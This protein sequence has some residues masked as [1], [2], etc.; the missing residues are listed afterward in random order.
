MD[1]DRSLSPPASKRLRVSDARNDSRPP[2]SSAS[3]SSSDR[4]SL[5]PHSSSCPV[6]SSASSSSSPTFDTSSSTQPPPP[7]PLSGPPPPTS[8]GPKALIPKKRLAGVIQ[9]SDGSI[10]YSGARYVL[11]EPCAAPELPP[12]PLA[13]LLAVRTAFLPYLSDADAGS[14]LRAVGST[15]TASAL[16]S[17]FTFRRHVFQADTPAQLRRMWQ[18]YE[19]YGLRASHMCLHQTPTVG[20]R[21]FG[22]WTDRS[23][24]PPSLTALLLTSSTL[25]ERVAKGRLD[26]Q[27]VFSSEVAQVI[28]CPWTRLS[29]QGAPQ[30]LQRMLSAGE[31]REYSLTLT[32]PF[33]PVK[34]LPEYAD[35][36]GADQFID[37]LPL[38][39]LPAHILRLHITVPF[40]D[41][42]SLGAGVLPAQLQVLQI[43][44]C[45]PAAHPPLPVAALPLNLTHLVLLQY[46]APLLPGVLPN[47]LVQLYLRRWN[48]QL[49]P[50]VLPASL[51]ALQLGHFDQPL[52]AGALPIGLT[53]LTLVRFKQVIGEGV[54]PVGLFSLDMGSGWIPSLPTQSKLPPSL[55]VLT[56]QTT[57]AH[58][59]GHLPPL[60]VDLEVLRWQHYDTR[61]P[62]QQFQLPAQL[63]VL[64]LLRCDIDETTSDAAAIPVGVRYL[65]LPRPFKE[66][67][68][69]GRFPLRPDIKVSFTV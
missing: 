50:D 2:V 69:D 1:P 63:Q 33:R 35:S 38:H 24:W 62:L 61:L 46:T 7:P 36:E 66:R 25:A 22:A 15:T 17:G 58:P 29:Q 31:R 3:S 55:R 47:S 54:L 45:L 42:F 9:F 41:Q 39:L 43:D 37:A 6:C 12:H 32:E 11:S 26:G 23:L 57:G 10:Y 64:D 27:G 34:A 20:V 4:T 18:L 68:Q 59:P 5:S 28:D 21:D 52:V 49:D 19:Q 48:Q 40:S 60:P 53:H 14:L 65:R 16:L 8:D 44:R 30:R 51:K 67:V 13:V 56:L